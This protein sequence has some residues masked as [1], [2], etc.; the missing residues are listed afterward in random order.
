MGIKKYEV[1]TE[2]EVH[3]VSASSAAIEAG[4]LVFY[5]EKQELVAA[6]AAWFS[7]TVMEEGGK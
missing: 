5:G 1:H 2:T 4:Y 7:F 6:Y 3:N